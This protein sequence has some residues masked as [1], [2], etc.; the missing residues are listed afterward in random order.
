MRPPRGSSAAADDG[1][2]LST[3]D[4]LLHAAAYCATA[5]LMTMPADA[6]LQ[7]ALLLSRARS[8]AADR[9]ARVA[10]RSTELALQSALL[11]CAETILAPPTAAPPP[12][13]ECP[14]IAP[15]KLAVVLSLKRECECA[16]VTVTNGGA[17]AAG[18]PQGAARLQGGPTSPGGLSAGYV[19]VARMLVE[20]ALALHHSHAAFAERPDV[21]RAVTELKAL[22]Q[23]WSPTPPAPRMW[24]ELI[25]SGAVASEEHREYLL[26]TVPPKALPDTTRAHAADL[27]KQPSDG[28][29][30][31]QILWRIPP[32]SSRPVPAK[33]IIH[34][35]RIDH[36]PT[37]ADVSMSAVPLTY[38]VDP[39]SGESEDA[40]FSFLSGCRLVAGCA[41]VVVGGGAVPYH[42][43][44]LQGPPLGGC[45]STL[46]REQNRFAAL[47]VGLGAPNDLMTQS[48]SL[49][50]SAVLFRADLEPVVLEEARAV[51]AAL[52]HAESELEAGI[53]PVVVLRP[54]NFERFFRAEKVLLPP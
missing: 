11:A 12:G 14:L 16:G 47:A 30:G 33:R 40:C 48:L 54:Q 15:F 5:G 1:A 21:R 3:R 53:D 19:D 39:E 41:S 22:A 29:V 28:V 35:V 7:I 8:L 38:D 44:L 20:A 23:V 50:G 32:A 24:A 45:N 18:A 31:E 26:R 43:A 25:E 52:K 49:L 4:V 27:Q 6:H 36:G 17:A 2:T 37:A 34:C 13:V 51:F 42:I 46:R 10:A 9:R